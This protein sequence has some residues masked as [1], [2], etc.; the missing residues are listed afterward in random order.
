MEMTLKSLEFA[1]EF[2]ARYLV[3]HM[4]SVPRMPHRKWTGK[5][6]R[7]L[8]EGVKTDTYLEKIR[9]RCIRKR[10]KIGKLYFQRSL[11]ALENIVEKA[12]EYQVKLAIESR[13]RYE[14]VPSEEEMLILQEHFSGKRTWD[15]CLTTYEVATIEVRVAA[16]NT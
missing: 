10:R 5:L 3:L 13:S 9:L 14:D 6:T 1:A 7:M 11:D 15:V 4:G 12:S 16:S 2:K 8:K